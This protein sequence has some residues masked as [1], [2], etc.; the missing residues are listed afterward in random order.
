MGGGITYLGLG[1]VLSGVS[2]ASGSGVISGIGGIFGALGLIAGIIGVIS[3]IVLM[4]AGIMVYRTPAKA[5]MWGIIGIVFAVISL[6]GGGG[7]LI[8]FILALIG[9]IM[10]LVSKSS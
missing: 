1:A 3:G 9:G 10:A 6:F 4:L 8:G 2:S 5:K 7:F